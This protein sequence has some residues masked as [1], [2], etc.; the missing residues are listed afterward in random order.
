MGNNT[1]YTMICCNSQK[2]TQMEDVDI[3]KN[4]KENNNNINYKDVNLN[5]IN[6]NKDEINKIKQKSNYKKVKTLSNI[7]S[8]KKKSK[9]NDDTKSQKD[10]NIALY[11][12]TFQILNNTQQFI[13][14]SN[15]INLFKN[16]LA[17]NNKIYKSC[18]NSKIDFKNS[19]VFSR[20]NNIE[21]IFQLNI[22]TKLILSGEL[23][24]NEIIEIDKFGMKNGLRKKHDGNSIFGIKN[25]NDNTNQYIYDYL[26]DLKNE[27]NISHL[28]KKLNIGK[29]FEIFLDKKDKI[30]VLYFSHSSLLLYYKIK[31][32]LF[33]DEDKEYYL[34]LGDIFLTIEVKPSFNSN[35]KI[36]NIKVEIEDEKPKKYSFE[37]KDIPIKIGRVNS[38]INIPKN[39]I[40]KTHGII[41]ISNNIFFYKDMKSTNGSTLLLKEDDYLRIKG[42][43]NF[44]LEDISFKIK[45]VENNET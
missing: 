30:Y 43:M 39:S 29:V 2:S 5:D 41:D 28:N 20:I 14:I 21:D 36:I 38:S 24:L 6:I 16:N 23:F 15:K 32:S 25:N 3:N 45:E 1:L 17:N 31:N 33:F 12:N 10:P 44:K 34:I 7:T 8:N 9:K 22:K 40:S 11:N 18:N 42:E 26:I 13:S 35:E 27:E 37:R 4:I 19:S